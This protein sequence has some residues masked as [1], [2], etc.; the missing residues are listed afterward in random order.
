MERLCQMD[1][2][3]NAGPP[4]HLDLRT[5]K[6][7]SLPHLARAMESSWKV[8]RLVEQERDKL[9]TWCRDFCAW[10]GKMLGMP[11]RYYP[12]LTSLARAKKDTSCMMF[13]VLVVLL[14]VLLTSFATHDCLRSCALR[15]VLS[16]FMMH[17]SGIHHRLRRRNLP[18]C[19]SINIMTQDW[20][21]KPEA[22]HFEGM[23][24]KRGHA[25]GNR[26][27]VNLSRGQAIRDGT[28]QAGQQ[29]FR[30]AVASRCQLLE[31]FLLQGMLV[32]W[33]QASHLMS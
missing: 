9:C 11:N 17:S 16:A 19:T 27:N 28:V 26:S 12:A 6:S 8:S 1:W 32:D 2:K 5:S 20:Q 14:V 33:H 30:I 24:C 15:K 29:H 7:R 22:Q 21:C 18:F 3:L 25:G 23:C 10:I 4:Q 31:R 13:S